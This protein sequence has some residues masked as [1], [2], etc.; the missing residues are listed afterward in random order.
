ML[1]RAPETTIFSSGQLLALVIL[2][3]IYDETR[4][5]WGNPSLSATTEK[6]RRSGAFF[7]VRRIQWDSNAVK[8]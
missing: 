3:S 1:Q 4:R 2:N 8:K 6:H 5:E 7:V